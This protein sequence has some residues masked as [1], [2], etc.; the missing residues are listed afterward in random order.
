[1]TTSTTNAAEVVVGRLSE[2]DDP[3]CRE[4]EIATGDWPFAGFVVRQGERVFAYRNYCMHVGHPL[5]WVPDDFLTRDR[6]HIIC[7]SHGAM[8]EIDSGLCIAGPCTGKKLTT[9]DACVRDDVIYV[10]WPA[11]GAVGHRP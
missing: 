1:M 8:Y 3:G 2:L 6:R 11:S 9:L 5:N 7:A 4:F 10:A